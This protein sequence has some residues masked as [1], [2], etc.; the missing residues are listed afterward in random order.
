[1]WN[2]IYHRRSHNQKAFIMSAA[3]S[4]ALSPP[5]AQTSKTQSANAFLKCR[6]ALSCASLSCNDGPD[7]RYLEQIALAWTF[8][9]SVQLFKTAGPS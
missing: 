2:E 4:A 9:F 1:M 7:P 3:N 5:P 8:S 6:C